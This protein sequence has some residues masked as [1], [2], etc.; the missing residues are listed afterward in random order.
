MVLFFLPRRITTA[1]WAGTQWNPIRFKSS[2]ASVQT[3]CWPEVSPNAGEPVCPALPVHSERIQLHSRPLV[4]WE[5]RKS[6]AAVVCSELRRAVKSSD[7]KI[8]NTL[9]TITAPT[10]EHAPPKTAICVRSVHPDQP[11]ICI[12][13]IAFLNVS[14][15][16]ATQLPSGL[17][18]KRKEIKLQQ[19]NM[20]PCFTQ[21]LWTLHWPIHWSHTG[22]VQPTAGYLAGYLAGY[23]FVKVPEK[24][25]YK[26]NYLHTV[27]SNLVLL[28]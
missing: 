11:G 10:R 27:Y 28:S 5:N 25:E 8:N 7:P 12:I 13:A 4:F 14:K 23:F 3:P 26:C 15:H 16:S 2:C 21:A 18:W 17:P 6:R 1:H 24:V 19:L 22:P 20:W 9:N